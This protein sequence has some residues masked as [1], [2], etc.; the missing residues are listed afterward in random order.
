MRRP[1]ITRTLI[2]L[3]AGAS[4]A[5]ALSACGTDSV[6]ADA[7]L[8]AG[9]QA[10]VK[11]CGSCHVLNRAGTKGDAGP[12]PRR[13][14]PAVVPGR[15]RA[16]HRA[17][18]RLPADPSSGAPERGQPGLH[19]APSSSRA[20]SPRTSP[21]TSRASPRCPARTQGGCGSAVAA[22]GAGKPVAAKGGK[23]EMP[24]D[25][26]RPARVH[27]E[28]RHGARRGAGD[29]LE[30]RVLDAARHRARGQRR[31][32]EGRDRVQ[33][34]RLEGLG[35]AQGRRVHV[36]LH[37]AR[38]PR[39]RHAGQAH[40]QVAPRAPAARAPQPC[41][42]PA[43]R[44]SPWR[45]ATSSDDRDADRQHAQQER[46]RGLLGLPGRSH[47]TDSYPRSGRAPR[48]CRSSCTR[49]PT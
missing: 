45:A 19:A 44:R 11:S 30:E 5:A 36:L 22:P 39:G 2:A 18:R 34:R 48:G 8:I 21:R 49:R 33:R 37:A 43:A 31:Q 12:E 28:G 25:P 1:P 38:P 4:L 20:S 26:E 17:R 41:A 24:A 14:L 13:G 6:P 32:R 23:L 10:F 29:R 9:K 35:D 7:D 40:R 46:E 3:A 47:A 16:R 27:H 15:L 42:A